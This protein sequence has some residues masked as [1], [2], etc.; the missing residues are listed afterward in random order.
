MAS[1]VTLRVSPPPR[2]GRKGLTG[3]LPYLA[4]T[5]DRCFPGACVHYPCLLKFS[6]INSSLS[7][8]V[9]NAGS[10]STF[11]PCMNKSPCLP[12]CSEQ[13]GFS[14][15]GYAS[16]YFCPLP[17]RG[18]FVL[19]SQLQLI[20]MSVSWRCLKYSYHL[21]S[22]YPVDTMFANNFQILPF[23]LT[24]VLEK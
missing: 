24:I 2:R 7:S 22:I 10:G 8:F 9:Q 13:G 17:W 18:Y 19:F 16:L 20:L 1:L 11:S 3:V 15:Y 12:P 5:Q 23:V 4:Q 6:N 21:F 14:L